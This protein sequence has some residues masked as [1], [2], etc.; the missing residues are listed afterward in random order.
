MSLGF[1]GHGLA[2]SVLRARAG[3]GPARRLSECSW[4][5]VARS[6]ARFAR[7]GGRA[8]VRGRALAACARAL[9]SRPSGRPAVALLVAAVDVSLPPPPAFH[10][11]F[12]VRDRFHVVRECAYGRAR[13]PVRCARPSPVLL[14]NCVRWRGAARPPAPPA[15]ARRRLL[16]SVRVAGAS[17]R[18]PRARARARS[19]HPRPRAALAH[20]PRGARG[21]K[22][23]LRCR[24]QMPRS[25]AIRGCPTLVMQEWSK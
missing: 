2:W 23:A 24:E 11:A 16:A 3:V 1:Y 6:R 10:E 8:R 20:R 7:A 4:A 12:S 14:M 19:R 22:S 17:A 15:R 21:W 25:P 5:R 9:R 13:R 18:P